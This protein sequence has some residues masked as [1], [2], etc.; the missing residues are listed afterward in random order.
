MEKIVITQISQIKYINEE[1]EDNIAGTNPKI[2]YV[3]TINRTFKAKNTIMDGKLKNSNSTRSEQSRE[4][5][6]NSLKSSLKH[7]IHFNLKWN[8]LKFFLLKLLSPVFFCSIFLY[9]LIIIQSYIEDYCFRQY[10]CACQHFLS[11]IYTAFKEFLH[12]DITSISWTYFAFSYLFKQFREKY[13]LKII[14]LALHFLLYFILYGIFFENRKEDMLGTIR[15]YKTCVSIGIFIFLAVIL[16]FFFKECTKILFKKMTK[17]C[18]LTCLYLFHI[19]FIQ[20]TFRLYF[21][22]Y[23]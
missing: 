13:Y 9:L 17:F 11:Y 20:N 22:I 6:N 2:E 19:L 23:I 7:S 18:F 1:E 21:F 4:N 10:F 3:G 5:E 15:I 12:L 8:P 16:S 14:F